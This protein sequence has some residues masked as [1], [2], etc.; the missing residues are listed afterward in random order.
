MEKSINP[1]I[2]NLESVRI[3]E[4]KAERIEGDIA[5]FTV[6]RQH[7]MP[8]NGLSRQVQKDIITSII[9][10]QKID[11]IIGSIITGGGKL[12]FIA[13]G[14]LIEVSQMQTIDEAKG[15]IQLGQ[16]LT[17]TRNFYDQIAEIKALGK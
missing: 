13:G 12:A 17:N 11:G 1:V 2:R 8:V 9:E 10:V 4:L 16:K 5:L 6:D 15:M 7:R 3:G 14:D